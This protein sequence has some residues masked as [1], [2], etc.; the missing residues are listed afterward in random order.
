MEVR[1]VERMEV[2]AQA[3]EAW[4]AVALVVEVAERGWRTSPGWRWAGRDR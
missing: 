3:A 1:A 2:V 4:A